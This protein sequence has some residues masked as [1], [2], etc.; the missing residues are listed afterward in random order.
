[1]GIY[2]KYIFPRLVDWTLGTQD[3]GELRSELL[4]EV[5]GKVLEIGFGT[6][7]NLPHYPKS[8]KELHIVDPN[9]G[10]HA[11]ALRRMAK[12]KIKIRGH[13]LKGESLP[14][15]DETFDSVV[16]TFTLCSIAMVAQALWEVRR[17]LKPHG[18]FFFLEHGLSP[19]PKIQVWQ[20]RLTPIQKWIGDGCHLDRPITMLVEAVGLK[21]EEVRNFYFKAFP[22]FLGYLYLGTA[23]KCS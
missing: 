1:M 15:K 4:S 14:H 8:V 11:L 5:R 23:E 3:V 10:M 16:C 7:L 12:S 6:G 18:R 13:V 2:S 19:E 17:V 20:H 21:V 9:P 22:R